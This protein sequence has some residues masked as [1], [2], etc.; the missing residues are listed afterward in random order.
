VSTTAVSCVIC[1][2]ALTHYE[3]TELAED[4]GEAL[5]SAC[6]RST[7]R[8]HRLTDRKRRELDQ[9]EQRVDRRLPNE[10]EEPDP[11]PT[12][13]EGEAA[14]TPARLVSG[15]AFILDEPEEIPAVWG[16]A[17]GTVA[18]AEGEPLMLVGPDGVGKTTLG[19]QIGLGR[20]GLRER[21]LGMR[22]ADDDRHL[23]YLALD[24]PRQ[25][26][27]SFRRMVTEDDRSL[28]N[29][30]MKVWK[31]PLPFDVVRD[32]AA[33]ADFVSEREA[34]TVIV[35]SL[36]DLATKLTDDEVGGRVNIAIQE[37]IARGVE[38]LV[39]HHQRKR[40]QGAGPPKSIADVYGSRWLTAGMGSVFCI[41][42]DPG[43]PIV[44]FTHLKQPADPIG[45]WNLQHDHDRGQTKVVDQVDALALVNASNG[46]T[47]EAVAALLFRTDTPTR[48]E[49]EKARRRLEK[50]A[51][52]FIDKRGGPPPNPV[53]YHP[54][55]AA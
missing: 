10:P 35:D 2:D 18:W 53:T 47:A 25:A 23:L 8:R 12:V 34:G 50:L 38:V 3:A 40:Q 29:E 37:V 54:K 9:Q 42:G 16:G 11:L 51:G 5:C 48:N 41:W 33:L 32:P 39:L 43:D 49:V 14:R 45:P 30:Q 7:D 31:G 13:D 17:S 55:E 26:A 28:L 21:V 24:R 52:P 4:V 36:K 19:Q 6:V 15:G 1:G 27:R 44:E 22:I 46:T 20:L